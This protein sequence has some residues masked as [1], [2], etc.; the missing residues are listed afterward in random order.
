MS[1]K[2]IIEGLFG[3]SVDHVNV[4][5]VDYVRRESDIAYR[6]LWH[7]DEISDLELDKA[8]S[9]LGGYLA[10]EN[11]KTAPDELIRKAYKKT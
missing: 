9:I 6:A 11:Y 5:E 10:K 1:R 7:V 3:V 4:V 8:I 2:N